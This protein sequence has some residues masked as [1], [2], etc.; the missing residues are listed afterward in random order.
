MLFGKNIGIKEDLKVEYQR[1]YFEF[2][3][4]DPLQE[5][6]KT[7]GGK[8]LEYPNGTVW[9]GSEPALSVSVNADENELLDAALTWLG[10]KFPSEIK[11]TPLV[12]DK[13]G[14]WVQVKNDKG[15]L[16][17]ETKR[18]SGIH[19]L[20]HYAGEGINWDIRKEA[21]DAAKPLDVEASLNKMRKEM[22]LQHPDWSENKIEKKLKLL[23]EAD[24]E[25]QAA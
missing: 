11:Y 24:E 5:L 10:N 1:P 20:L 25:E 17:V 14:K 13:D 9:K 15:E 22:K 3:E 12:K 23:M 21:L 18:V 16:I 8:P 6:T 19:Y 7:T 4:K 2:S